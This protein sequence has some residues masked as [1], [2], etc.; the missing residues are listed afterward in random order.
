MVR[1]RLLLWQRCSGFL[2]RALLFVTNVLSSEGVQVFQDLIH[3][4][5]RMVS[6][7]DRW[8]QMM[9]QIVINLCSKFYL[10][11]WALNSGQQNKIMEISV[12][13]GLPIRN[14]PHTTKLHLLL[15]I[16]L[17]DL[18]NNDRTSFCFDPWTI[19]FHLESDTEADG[20][21]SNRD[22]LLDGGE[23]L[24][25]HRLDAVTPFAWDITQPY[26]TLSGPRAAPTNLNTRLCVLLWLWPPRSLSQATST[27]TQ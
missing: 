20:R 14:D 8:M 7:I 13:N 2:H 22:T 11:S 21:N 25:S 17:L 27:C 10:R 5:G 15:R 9:Y 16:C 1:T 18:A 12:G 24:V 6:E 19:L 3:G 26:Q 4:E 23:S